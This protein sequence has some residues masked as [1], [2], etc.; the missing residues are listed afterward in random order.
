VFSKFKYERIPLSLIKLD[1]RNPRIVTP[2]KLKTQEDIIDYL[3]EYENLSEFLKKIASEGHN[4]GAERPY[5]VKLGKEYVVIEGN[6][7]IATYKLLTGLLSPPDEYAN[8][9]PSVSTAMKEELLAVDCSV[10]PSRDALLSIMANAHFGLGDKS[11]WGYL[12]SRKAVYDEW[13]SGKSIAQLSSA[14]GRKQGQ[15]RDLILEYQL[16]LEA[17]KLNWTPAE[18]KELLNPAVEFNPPVRFLQTTGHKSAIG[19]EFDRVNLKVKFLDKSAKEKFKH[20]V[21]KLVV[22]PSKGLGATSSYKD[23]FSDYVNNTVSAG[24][25]GGSA[26]A[27]DPKG[28][29][30][31]G[32]AGGGSGQSSGTS[33][34]KST[35]AGPKLAKGALFGYPVT[36]GNALHQQLM[37]E[38]KNINSENF[39]ASG[40][41]LLRSIIETILKSII[42][43]QGANQS[44]NLLSLETALDICLGNKVHLGKDDKKILKEFKKSHLDYV[45]LGAHGTIIPN[46]LRLMAAQDCIDQFVM[47]NI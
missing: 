46:H 10:A 19:I 41:A 26:G 39:P 28:G 5:V 30:S 18:K 1:D 6:T 11:K 3:F 16:Y 27:G 21:S 47:R 15:I 23:V 44:N 37:K 36:N 34:G 31:N 7:R 12:G 8:S 14:F 35:K 45:N 22:I 33:S 42:H 9:V 4:Q 13:K 20:L 25:G 17:L 32:G 43:D 29:S 38:A 24:S 40:T 2:E